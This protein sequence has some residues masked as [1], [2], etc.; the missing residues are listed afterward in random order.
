MPSTGQMN[1][2]FG[3]GFRTVSP[4]QMA[5]NAIGR[6]G[7]MFGRSRRSGLPMP[8]G[9]DEEPGVMPEGDNQPPKRGISDR[10]RSMLTGSR[11]AAIG[12]AAQAAGNVIGSYIASQPTRA[13]QKEEERR[14]RLQEQEGARIRDMLMPLVQ[15]QMERQKRIQEEEDRRRQ[16]MGY[17]G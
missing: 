15:S 4:Q 11:G 8:F 7:S 3:G 16:A 10:I 2:Q 9:D 6:G 12:G 5:L 14:A 13:R 1:Q 17:G